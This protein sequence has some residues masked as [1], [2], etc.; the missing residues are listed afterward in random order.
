[1]KQN[2]MHRFQI[3]LVGWSQARGNPLPEVSWYLGP[4]QLTGS[5]QESG[6]WTNQ[7]PGLGTNQEPGLGTNQKPGLGAN[8]ETAQGEDVSRQTLFLPRYTR[9]RI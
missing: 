9:D 7:Q 6:L 5:N 4:R 3:I 2:K 1:M 8:K